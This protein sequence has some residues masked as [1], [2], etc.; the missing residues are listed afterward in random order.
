MKRTGPWYSDVDCL[1]GGLCFASNSHCT[2]A[3]CNALHLKK[4]LTLSQEDGKFLLGS[5]ALKKCKRVVDFILVLNIICD[6]E[7]ALPLPPPQPPKELLS[8][9]RR[10]RHAVGLIF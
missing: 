3:R 8:G 1:A 6:S 5:L 10:R 7:P 4:I 9:F 2:E